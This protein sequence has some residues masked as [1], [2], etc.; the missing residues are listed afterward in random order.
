M[1][2]VYYVKTLMNV[3]ATNDSENIPKT[4]TRKQEALKGKPLNKP[5]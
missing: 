5:K 3:N 4:E 1:G 2:E